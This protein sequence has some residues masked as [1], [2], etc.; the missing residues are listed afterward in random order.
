MRSLKGNKPVLQITT[1]DGAIFENSDPLTLVFAETN[2]LSSVVL[3][4]VMPPLSQ[5]YIEACAQMKIGIFF[6]S[7]F[8]PYFHELKCFRF[9][10]I[11]IILCR[12]S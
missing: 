7:A 8:T 1:A 3:E 4:W 12:R 10:Q 11:Q 6:E 2:P 9:S 5:R